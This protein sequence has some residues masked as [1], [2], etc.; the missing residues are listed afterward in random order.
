VSGEE[1]AGYDVFLS[2]NSR[3]RAAVQRIARALEKSG[4]KVWAD[5]K[6]P[7]GSV[8][9]TEIE[10]VIRQ[11]RSAAF[12]VG[13]AGMGEWHETERQAFHVRRTRIIPVILPGVAADFEPPPF[14]E[15]LSWID[16]RKKGITREAMDRLVEGIRVAAV[17]PAG[18]PKPVVPRAPIPWRHVLRFAAL[19]L[20]VAA[21]VAGGVYGWRSFRAASARRHPAAAAASPWKAKVPLPRPSVAVLDFANRSANRDLDWLGGALAEAV[22]ARLGAGGAVRAADRETVVPGESDLLLPPRSEVPAADL[23]RL[24]R[25]LGVDWIVSGAYAPVG[26][27]TAVRLD[28]ALYDAQGRKAGQASET[29]EAAAWLD[30][31]DR[32]GESSPETSF[33][34]RLGA[35]PLN[36]ADARHYRTLF[37]ADAETAKLYF[38][39]LERGRRWDQGGAA[40]LLGQAVK[41]AP[42]TWVLVDLARTDLALG[43]PAEAGTALAAASRL[44]GQAKGTPAALSAEDE[45]RF[46]KIEK[47]I[48]SDRAGV[49]QS[50]EALFREFFPDDLGYGI[51]AAEDLVNAG[52]AADGLRLCAELRSLPGAEAHP[53]LDLEEGQALFTQQSYPRA[54]ASL[55][56]AVSKA[57]S[58][59]AIWGEA[60]ARFILSEVL[61]DT[62]ET[63]AAEEQL[64]LAR[65]GFERTGD[66]LGVAQTI[67][68]R[69]YLYSN[70]DL[71]TAETLYQEASE[72][73]ET[74]GYSTQKVE[75]LFGWSAVL[76][77][78]GDE[79]G[80]RKRSEEAAALLAK[81]PFSESA[82]FAAYNEGMQLHLAGQLTA[83]RGRYETARAVFSRLNQRA[84][85]GIALSSLGEIEAMEG[86][87]QSAAEIEREALTVDEAEGAADMVA[88]V[89]VDI[90]RGL[91]ATGNYFAAR[92]RYELAQRGVKPA[93]GNPPRS[94]ETLAEALLA[95]AELE[96]RT[97]KSAEAERQAREAEAVAAGAG[98]PT[99][100]SRA[101]SLLA[102]SLLDKG[103]KDE[104]RKA[105]VEAVGLAKGDFRAVQESAITAA[106][107]RAAMGEVDPALAALQATAAAAAKAGMVLYELESLLAEGEVELADGR[108]QPARR[109]LGGL[110]T[111]AA[112]LGY[113]E[114]V[115]RVAA[116]L[117]G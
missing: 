53:G 31:A 37:P 70:L 8:W 10:T 41:R 91:A 58:I 23:A 93:G 104:A 32:A 22:S 1:D 7:S 49:A 26:G 76:L 63:P 85:Y 80:A 83:A 92:Q 19:G 21:V 42:H 40:E 79:A 69:A 9:L 14:L 25:L 113:G 117:G 89:N 29:G 99:F 81:S 13:P 48:A 54:R 20:A 102:L 27:T 46:E 72:R 17:E 114:M 86:R 55:E 103:K 50:A 101:L 12:F 90:G 88:Y 59:G 30:L 77:R 16:L 105:A 52:A 15:R 39:G 3:D 45:R 18:L 2:Y 60:R 44:A 51:L 56:R 38:Q 106:R 43:R 62:G 116:A 47:K 34:R 24:R 66:L 68:N 57:R 108:V 6:M 65:K 107:T 5:W 84:Y 73:Y 35:A 75:V 97:G 33:R 111:R 96:L 98:L 11:A 115:K 100:R 64:G 74:L 110:S 95:L 82:G 28:L 71:T 78:K 36:L 94:P 67:Q 87:F 4:L 109:L 61:L 112:G